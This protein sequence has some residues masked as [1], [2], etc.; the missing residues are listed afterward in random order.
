MFKEE[1]LRSRGSSRY[2][3]LF[4]LDIEIS[5]FEIFLRFDLEYLGLEK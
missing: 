4:V 3:F 5:S 1:H 2:N